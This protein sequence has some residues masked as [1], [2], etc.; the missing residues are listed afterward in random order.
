MSDADTE[1]LMCRNR[2]GE[3]MYRKVLRFFKNV[4]KNPADPKE[5]SLFLT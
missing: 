3:S 1:L 2:I 5:S 4:C